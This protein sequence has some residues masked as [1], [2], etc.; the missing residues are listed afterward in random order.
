MKGWTLMYSSQSFG[1]CACTYEDFKSGDFMI[2]TIQLSIYQICPI[3]DFY[4]KCLFLTYE[5][6]MRRHLLLAVVQGFY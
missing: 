4:F 1:N 2:V 6:K 3:L 5:V